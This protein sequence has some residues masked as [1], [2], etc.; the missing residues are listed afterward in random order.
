M[1]S[2]TR[3]CVGRLGS[4]KGKEEVLAVAHARGMVPFPYGDARSSMTPEVAVAL[5]KR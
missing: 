4:Q 3:A 5:R 1:M 2:S